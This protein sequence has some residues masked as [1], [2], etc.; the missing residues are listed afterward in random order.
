MCMEPKDL[1]QL[2]AATGDPVAYMLFKAV[3]EEESGQVNGVGRDD[4]GPPAD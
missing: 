3:D 2:F 4:L 1:W